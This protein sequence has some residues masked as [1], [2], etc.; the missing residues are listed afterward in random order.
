MDLIKSDP[1]IQ[2]LKSDETL[3]I[4]KASRGP[5]SHYLLIARLGLGWEGPDTPH[6]H[7]SVGIPSNQA[8]ICPDEVPAEGNPSRPFGACQTGAPAE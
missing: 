1:L 3:N 2:Y 4:Q 6:Q 8:Y 7:M 5:G